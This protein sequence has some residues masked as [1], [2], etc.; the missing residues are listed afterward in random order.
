MSTQFAIKE[1]L[2]CKL[3]V[4]LHPKLKNQSQLKGS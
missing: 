1:L 4:F 2:N 3:D